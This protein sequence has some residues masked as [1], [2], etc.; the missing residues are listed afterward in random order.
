[1]IYIK[2]LFLIVLS[3]VLS[4]MDISFFS[5]LGVYGATILTSFIFMII[6]TLVDKTK[7]DY[8]IV[9][10]SL[11][12]FFSIFSSLPLFPIMVNFF[13]IPAAISYIRKYYLPE[14]SLIVSPLYFLVATFIFEGVLLIYS[15]AW[16]NEGLLTFSWFVFINTMVGVIVYYFYLKIRKRFKSFEIKI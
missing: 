1:M 8:I 6:F 7:K 11:V 5:F 14:P 13:L 9:S 15:K 12:L 4:F 2:Y 3:F 10:L 16:N